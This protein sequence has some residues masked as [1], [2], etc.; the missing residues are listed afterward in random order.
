MLLGMFKGWPKA[1]LMAGGDEVLASGR[2]FII[3][4]EASE[5][6]ASGNQRTMSLELFHFLCSPPAAC[7]PERHCA[8]FFLTQFVCLGTC[9]QCTT[10][11]SNYRQLHLLTFRNSPLPIYHLGLSRLLESNRDIPAK[12]VSRQPHPPC[13]LR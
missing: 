1:L 3:K 6:A 8:N 7:S 10:V 13:P 4:A 2:T 11:R 12:A 5:M 9:W